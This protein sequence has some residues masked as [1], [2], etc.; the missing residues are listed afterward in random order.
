M[1]PQ[2]I[3]KFLSKVQQVG[4]CWMWSGSKTSA[5]YGQIWTGRMNYS[6]RFSY[7]LFVGIIP[8]GMTLDHLCRNR[9]CVNPDH[10]EAVSLKENILR[11]YNSAAINSKKTQCPQGHPY[12]GVNNQG[13]RICQTCHNEKR[14]VK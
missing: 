13:S 1:N 11:G 7:E 14:R 12:S 2:L 3:Q 6:H 4:N 5:G 8:K 10:L 9:A